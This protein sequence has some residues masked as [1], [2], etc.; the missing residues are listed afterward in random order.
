MRAIEQ[1]FPVV[2]FIMLYMLFFPGEKMEKVRACSLDLNMVMIVV[3]QQ[4]HTITPTGKRA[5]G[6]SKDP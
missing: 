6:R 4:L 2:L 1:Y 3:L 5:V